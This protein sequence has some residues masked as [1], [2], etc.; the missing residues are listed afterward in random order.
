MRASFF[1]L[2]RGLLLASFSIVLGL[3]TTHQARAQAGPIKPPETYNPVDA[4]GVNLLS[5]SMTATTPTVSIGPKGGLSYS[6]SYDSGSITAWSDNING[7]VATST[8]TG[9]PWYTVTMMGQAFPFKRTG[10]TFA[11]QE[12]STASLVISGGSFILTLLDG[13]VATYS[14]AYP[15]YMLGVVNNLGSIVKIVSPNGRTIDFT[16]TSALSYNTPV[17]RLQS[18]NSSDGYQLH[19]DYVANSNTNGDVNAIPSAWYSVAKVTALNNAIDACAPAALACT[20]SRAWP[21]LTFASSGNTKTVTDALNRVTTYIFTNGILTGVRRPGRASGQDVLVSYNGESQ[22]VEQVTTDAGNYTYAIP[23]AYK[24]GFPAAPNQT[25]TNSATTVTDP[26]GHTR[27]VTSRSTLVDLATHHRVSRLHTV[28]NGVEN[29]TQYGYTNFRLSSISRLTDYNGTSYAFDARGNITTVTQSPKVNSGASPI[30][31]TTATYPATCDASN[32]RICNQPVSVTDARGAVTT[33]TYDPAHGGVLTATSPSPASGAVQPQVRTTYAAFNAWYKNAAGVIVQDVRPIYL[34]TG[35]SQCATQGPANGAT[36]APCAGTADEI[37]STIAYQAG[38]ASMASNLLPVSTTRRNGL[39][40]NQAGA[41]AATTAMTYGPYGDVEA[42]DG[43]LAG[44]ADVTRTYYN[45]ARQAIGTINPDPDDAGALLYRATRTT[46]ADDGQVLSVE[47]GTATNQSDTGMA[48]FS[49]L[50]KL[51]TGYDVAGRKISD[52][53]VVGGVTQALTQYAYDAANRLICS[54]VRMNPTATQ[55]SSACTPTLGGPD[56]NDRVTYT[57]YDAADRVI[58]ITSGYQGSSPRV[59]K[60]VTYTGNGL[61]QTV[62]D[63]KGNLTTYEYDAFDRLAKVRYPSAANGAVSACGLPQGGCDYEEYGYDAAGNRTSWRRRDGT[64]VAFTY[65]ALNRANSGL[66]GE[67][68]AY[69]NLGRRTSATYGGGATTASYD[70]LGRMTGEDTYGHPLTYQYDLAGRRTRMTWWDGVYVT[71]DYYRSGEIANIYEN[72]ATRI[73][74]YAYDNLG[75]RDLAWQGLGAKAVS[76]DYDYDAASRLASLKLDLAGTAQDQTWTFTYNAASQVKTRAAS[77]GLYEWSG[78][79]AAKSYTVNGLNQYAAAAGITLAY[80]ARGNLTN[81]GTKT[82]G[83]DLL[84]NLTSTSTGVSLAYEPTGRLWRVSTG[85]EATAFIYSGSDLIAELDGATGA[86]L[87][88]YVP[89]PGTDTPIAWYEGSGTTDRRWLMADPQGSI[90][91]VTNSVGALIGSVPNTYD[92]YGAPGGNFGRFQYTG[93]IWLPEVGLYHYKARAYSPVLGRFLQ[94]DPI[95]YGDGLNWYAYVGNDPTNATDPDGMLRWTSTTSCAPYSGEGDGVSGGYCQTTF[96]SSGGDDSL[97][98]ALQ[99]AV[100]NYFTPSNG[101]GC[102]A[103]VVGGAAIG[104]TAGAVGGAVIGGAGGAVAGG[105]VLSLGTAPAGA[106][107]GANLG[108]Q[109]GTV[110]GG[111]GGWLTSPSCHSST[112][113][114]DGNGNTGHG[115]QRASEARAGDSG[116]QVGDANR[117]VREGR[118]FIDTETG[119]TVHVS[120][121]RVVITGQNGRVTQFV[122]SR[123]NT[124]A[125][126]ASGKWVPQ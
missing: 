84:N 77:N 1:R 98:G 20:Y 70:A 104:G 124:Q 17:Y 116:R 18:V 10:D 63:G 103:A 14:S 71:Y 32:F 19:F 2:M 107:A 118:K 112:A 44:A 39:A 53:L 88:R 36:P 34:P 13:T 60:A 125:R 85:A 117:V 57:E 9:D 69:D 52:S 58:K 59:E 102:G 55:Q 96:S 109:A 6:Q 119:A 76:E 94:T 108:G 29:A 30:V 92:E 28:S 87:R 86:I 95:G 81:D 16:Y 4:N 15:S 80:D 41:L 120:G 65:D 5:G 68:Y 56:G 97:S 26:L 73:A 90:V 123:A 75:R 113:N 111:F 42:V 37:K 46:Y 38:A 79:Q 101:P 91:A 54:T 31:V 61:E 43:P 35:T 22:M 62:A 23:D 66:R 12:G 45:A 50:Q 72:G 64:T 126:I 93:Q 100:T 67:A 74:A 121:N 89:G 51:T 21:S 78:A 106:A 11:A 122:N 47:T 7:M 8:L 40:S 110:L 3:S 27:I 49:P 24:N 82:Y 105:G 83:Y 114:G 48:T 25:I 33:F 115:E 99:R